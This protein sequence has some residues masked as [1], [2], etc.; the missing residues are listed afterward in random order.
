MRLVHDGRPLNSH[1][2]FRVNPLPRLAV[3]AACT[4][5]ATTF[6]EAQ[7][8]STETAATPVAEQAA[9]L[10]TGAN[11]PAAESTAA[12]TS[13]PADAGVTAPSPDAIAAPTPAADNGGFRYNYP[14]RDEG[15]RAQD[16]ASGANPADVPSDEA[17]RNVESREFET[18]G[19]QG[20][21]AAMPDIGEGR[22]ERSPFRFSF[23]VY[24]G[25]NSNVN[26][27][28]SGGTGSMYTQLSAGIGY[29]FG[30]SRLKLNTSLSAGL[31]YYYDQNNLD[32]NGLFPTINFI[33]GATYAASPRL[34]ISL[35]TLTALQSQ[36]NYLIAGAPNANLG[37]YI[38]SDTSLGVKY[39]W[40]PKLATT[41]TYNP[42]I[43]YFL[44]N[45]QNEIQGRFEQ[46]VGQQFIFL[47][48]PTTSLVAE[49]RFDTRNYF[50]AQDLNSIGNYALLGFDHTLN[51]RSTLSFRGGVEQRF[52]QNPTPGQSSSNDYLGPFAQL[53]MNYALGRYTTVG[54]LGRYGTTASGMSNYNQGQQ[55][56]L[57]VNASH[58]FT[59]RLGATV[60]FNYQNNYYT[61][62]D[63][64]VDGINYAPNFYNNIFNT[65]LNLNYQLTRSWSLLGGCSYSTLMSTDT[66]SQQDY[67]QAIVFL[68]TEFSF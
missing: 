30:T 59:R 18:V 19:E 68:G 15:G 4:A 33:L 47:W 3:L 14:V 20:A 42:R 34:D 2:I 10:A 11:V 67:N 39:L 49:Y 52:N 9:A 17:L 63:S 46:T 32:D 13:A 22:F 5:L 41:T 29:E 64:T 44:Q 60:F 7:E 57:G 40:M 38:I 16:T 35:S 61:Q 6:S 31:T 37:N 26:T 8:S 53:N 51:P 54:L 36:P 1:S 24:E 21:T 56:L 12:A 23:A 43:F 45:D 62:P 58:Q 48:K 65:G 25:Y 27:Q 55:L 66:A 28:E 50:D